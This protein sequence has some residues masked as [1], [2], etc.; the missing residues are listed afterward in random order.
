MDSAAYLAQLQMLLPPGAAWSRA[1]EATLTDV[2]RA[3]AEE[4]SRV[5]E[6]GTDLLDEAD[7]RTTYELLDDWEGASGLPAPCLAEIEQTVQQRRDALVGHLT[8]RGGQSPAYYI[9]VALALG[10]VITITEFYLHT[11]NDDVEYPIIEEG[12]AYAW[13]VNAAAT[14]VTEITVLDDVEQPLAWW[15]NELLECV[16][17]RLKPAHTE[18]V[19][20]YS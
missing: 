4:L 13:Q 18:V 17:R 14:T 19:F 2:L 1:A 20:A 16:L 15:G 9:A 7:P 6:R 11:V 5:D 3:W 8:A 12:W 10:F